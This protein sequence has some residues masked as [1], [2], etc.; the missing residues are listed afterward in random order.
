VIEVLNVTRTP[1]DKT[2]VAMWEMVITEPPVGVVTQ[3]QIEYRET[4]EGNER[5]AS[6]VFH[7]RQFNSLWVN[8]VINANS[9]EVR[10]RVGR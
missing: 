9:Y 2:L 7:S 8:N 10:V 5:P 1:D 3:Y 6:I 4:K